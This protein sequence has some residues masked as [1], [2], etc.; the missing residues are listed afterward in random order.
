MRVEKYVR[1][2][3]WAPNTIRGAS[4]WQANSEGS[5]YASGNQEPLGA[6]SVKC[7]RCS[8]QESLS[9]FK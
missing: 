6:L 7:H 5:K 1:K 2:M 4:F 8:R 9:G 3:D